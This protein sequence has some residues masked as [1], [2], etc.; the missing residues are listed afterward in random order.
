MTVTPCPECGKP[1]RRS[2]YQIKKL[3]P[4]Q[5]PC[6]SEQRWREHFEAETKKKE[7]TA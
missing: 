2:A 6:C 5:M 7:A 3:R 4:G 1:A